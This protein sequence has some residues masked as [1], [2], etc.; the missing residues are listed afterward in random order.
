MGT[1]NASELDKFEKGIDG[2]ILMAKTSGD[3]QAAFKTLDFGS[4]PPDIYLILDRLDQIMDKIRGQAGF[5][6]GGQAK[7][8]TR[9]VG[10]LELMKG[11][12]GARTDR[13][14]GCI[15]THCENIARHL[16]FH[17]KQNF[18]LPTM[19]KITGNEPKE[20]IEAFQ[21]EGKFDENSGTITFTKE[22]I[23]G[24]YD[25]TVKAGSTLPLDKMTRDQIL[26]KTLQMAIPLASAPSLP[27][28]ITE[29]IKERLRDYGIKGLEE[30]FDQQAQYMAQQQQGQQ[31]AQQTI[32]DKT[33]AETAKRDA[34][35]QQIGV[36]TYIKGATA[37][38]K[39][40]GVIPLE[41]K[42]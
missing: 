17:M 33:K 6:Q 10:E 24:E 31:Q 37:L 11:G 5:E 39:A 21:M 38:A 4:L 36:D 32:D 12:S 13:K 28:F 40:H 8:Q 1:M 41:A 27:P 42:V 22:D 35:A 20:I 23:A 26:D 15:E 18:D 2:T 34:Q 3:I 16:M 29:I 19:V 7:T 14:I 25:V 9:T 30:A